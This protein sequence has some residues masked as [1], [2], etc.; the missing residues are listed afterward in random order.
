MS[1]I[2]SNIIE[3]FKILNLEI[4]NILS[5]EENQSEIK[6][7]LIIILVL[8]YTSILGKNLKNFLHIYLYY[9]Y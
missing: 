8:E 3:Y 7:M 4:F 5:E 2:R 6:I 9:I 1:T